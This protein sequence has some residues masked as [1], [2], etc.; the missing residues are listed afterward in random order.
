MKWINHGS[1]KTSAGVISYFH[2]EDI[3]S[4]LTLKQAIEWVSNNRLAVDGYIKYGDIFIPDIN[5]VEI[6]QGKIIKR[7]EALEEYKDEAVKFIRA[8]EAWD[9]MICYI[10]TDEFILRSSTR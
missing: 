3:P 2:A 4:N 5:L 1:V 8:S 7:F 9:G 10:T 6:R